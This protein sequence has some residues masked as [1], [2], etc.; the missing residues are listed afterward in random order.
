MAAELGLVN[1]LCVLRASAV[2]GAF[3][4]RRGSERFREI[5][6]ENLRY[7]VSADLRLV[8]IR[9]LDRRVNAMDVVVIIQ[10]I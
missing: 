2:D 4:N 7:D 6:I 9:S 3:G 1:L 5:L 10:S 8:A